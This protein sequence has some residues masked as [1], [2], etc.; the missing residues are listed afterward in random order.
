MRNVV[1][2]QR[3]ILG[4][5]FRAAQISI[6]LFFFIPNCLEIC[7]NYLE[8]YVS[9]ALN[10]GFGHQTTEQYA[11]SSKPLSHLQA[12]VY[13]VPFASSILHSAFQKPIFQSSFARY[14]QSYLVSLSSAPTSPLIYAFHKK[15][16][17]TCY[18]PGNFTDT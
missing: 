15:L 7:L 9:T 12:S 8:N 6:K 16:L 11:K 5:L 3:V 1:S 10:L 2:I 13:T 17:R 4:L 14:S 18:M